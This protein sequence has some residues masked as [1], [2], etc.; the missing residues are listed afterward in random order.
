MNRGTLY[1]ISAPS[2]CGKGT[3]LDCVL[4]NNKNI[5]YSV[6]A[7][8][9]MPRDGEINGK[10][11]YFYTKDEFES[12]INSNGML[13]HASFCDNYYWT[14]KKQVEEKLE[15]GYDV[16]LEI[17]TN[18]AMQIKKNCPDAVL[19]FIL[20]PS[21]SELKRR[22]LK[23]GTETEDVINKRVSQAEREIKCAENYDYILIN[24]ELEEAIFNLEA[25]ILASK[26][27]I[28]NNNVKIK[29]V[30]ENA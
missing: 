22:L 23:R 14:P 9:R 11:Y 2:G 4:N 18:G 19:I 20:P 8:T 30:L 28:N 27:T 5:F 7:T 16:I 26:L 12:L 3:I 10:N 1:V 25:I 29:E 13:E 15:M 17:E 21:I 6:S 24:D